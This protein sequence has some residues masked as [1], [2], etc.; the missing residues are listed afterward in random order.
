MPR[1]IERSHVSTSRDGGNPELKHL[2][3]F[4]SRQTP[5]RAGKLTLGAAAREQ[6]PFYNY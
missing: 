4:Q 3:G 1:I 2:E 6:L 5:I